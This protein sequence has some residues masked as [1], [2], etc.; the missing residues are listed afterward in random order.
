[1]WKKSKILISSKSA[2][3]NSPEGGLVG[4]ELTEGKFEDKPEN[5]PRSADDVVDQ[6]LPPDHLAEMN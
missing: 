3:L 4:E 6:R 1:M 5:L 2:Q